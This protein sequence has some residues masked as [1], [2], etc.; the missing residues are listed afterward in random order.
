[1]RKTSDA[2]QYSALKNDVLVAK[3][4]REKIYALRAL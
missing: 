4:S 1:M 3:L 2:S